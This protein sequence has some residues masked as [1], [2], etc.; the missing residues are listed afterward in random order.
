M[1]NQ[2]I[3]LLYFMF[4]LFKEVKNKDYLVVES[5]DAHQK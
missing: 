4:I 1:H 3:K 5:H 2:K